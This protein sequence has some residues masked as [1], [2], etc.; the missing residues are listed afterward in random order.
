MGMPIAANLIGAGHEVIGFRRTDDADFRALGGTHAASAR[1]VAERCEIVLSC[2]PSDQALQEVVSG[3][4][5]IAGGD[6]T[7]RILVELS[8]LSPDMKARQAD[9][10]AGRG[11][12]M[13]DGAISGLP[14]M[15]AARR[16]IFLLSGDVDT[17]EAVRPVLEALTEKLF[18]M[19]AFGAAMKAKLCANLL[20]ASNIAATAETLAFGTKLGLDP[21]RLIEALKDGAGGSLQFTMRAG[22]MVR[23]DWHDVL[24]STAMLTKDIHLIEAAAAAIGAPVP[25]LASAART[26]RAGDRGWL[27]RNRR[28]VRLRGLRQS[29]RARRAGREFA[30]QTGD[31]AMTTYKLGTGL[32]GGRPTPIVLVGERVHTLAEVLGEE[33]P[34]DLAGVFADWPRIDALLAARAEAVSAAGRDPGG[35]DYLTPLANPRKVVCIGA[36]YSDHLAEMKGPDAP[37][38]PYAFM[39]PQTSL[40][41]HREEIRLPSGAAMIDWEAELG[42]IIGRSFGPGAAGDPL[43]AVAGYTVINDISARDWIESRPFVGIDWVMQKAWDQFQPTGPWITPAR[44]VPDPQRLPIELTLNEEVKQKSNTAEMIFGVREIIGHLA[45]MMTLE[46]GDIIATGTPAG[47]GFGRQPREFIKSG[48]QVRVTI[49][50]LGTLENRFV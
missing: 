24:G 35:I 46:P 39:R 6:C 40:A 20:V 19:G 16:A 12:A 41:A 1:E 36:N 11:G 15:V 10:L 49:D 14:P 43:D 32:I 28:R 50:T 31:K 3:P 45:G 17:F 37:A 5:G 38:F 29:G 48:D 27:R 44:F 30:G 47:V 22:R 25:V 18:Y 8:T 42:V 23:G 4:R 9:A 21:L 33:A 7:G 13:L 2:I 34:A 26:L